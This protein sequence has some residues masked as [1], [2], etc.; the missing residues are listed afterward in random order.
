MLKMHC[1][2][3][4]VSKNI[5][6]IY[7]KKIFLYIYSW[8]GSCST[9]PPSPSPDISHISETKMDIS[10]KEVKKEKIPE[11]DRS[12]L[13]AIIID[14]SPDDIIIAETQNDAIPESPKQPTTQ[15]IKPKK[16]TKGAK[17]DPIVIPETQ[18]NKT[19]KEPPCP[20]S[21]TVDIHE[22]VKQ[23]HQEDDIELSNSGIN[24]QLPIYSD[25]YK[26]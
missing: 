18:T 13:S 11:S 3:I 24:V 2:F 25:L 9:F 8:Y 7:K 15:S 23:E 19:K 26:I 14:D 6:Y 21:P 22:K 17:K 20:P 10:L 4:K 16:H 5:I 1:T 12:N